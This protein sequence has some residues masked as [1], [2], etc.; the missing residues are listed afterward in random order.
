LA[1][2]PIEVGIIGDDDTEY[3]HFNPTHPLD[4]AVAV[5]AVSCGDFLALETARRPFDDRFSAGGANSLGGGDVALSGLLG[6]LG[7]FVGVFEKDGLRV[8]VG[9]ARATAAPGLLDDLF[10]RK[11]GAFPKRRDLG[12]L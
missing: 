9:D 5:I 12:G 11:V 2:A 3:L 10:R 6:Q 4:L 7:R 8:C 1:P